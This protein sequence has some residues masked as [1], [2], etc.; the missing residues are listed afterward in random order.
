MPSHTHTAPHGHVA[1][2]IYYSDGSTGTVNAEMDPAFGFADYSDDG[3]VHGFQPTLP[4]DSGASSSAGGD[5]TSSAI[6]HVPDSYRMPF[7][8]PA[9]SSQNVLPVLAVAWADDVCPD[10]FEHLAA[11]DGLLIVGAP[12]GVAAGAN[13]PGHSHSFTG[14]SHAYTHSHGGSASGLFTDPDYA[15]GGSLWGDATLLD[16]PSS[17]PTGRYGTSAWNVA[18]SGPYQPDAAV[19][20]RHTININNIQSV[21][22]TLATASSQTSGVVSGTASLPPS[23]TLVTCVKV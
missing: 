4:T 8:L 17:S 12:A 21:A 22:A 10:G 23:K 20:H 15:P 14:T 13:A 9:D 3:H 16:M 18:V 2:A 1:S 11:A 7:I 5:I 19:G 6:V